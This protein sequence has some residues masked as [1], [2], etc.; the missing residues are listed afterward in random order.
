[1]TTLQG[2][3]D[4]QYAAGRVPGAV[5][6]VSRGGETELAT[7]GER[8]IGGPPMTSDSLFR[9]AS[10]TKP[11]VAAATMVLVERGVLGLDDAVDTW[12][13]EVA[14]P[15][16]LRDAGGPLD[17]VVPADRAITV[18][19]LLTLRGGHGFTADVQ[20]P[21]ARALQER[22]QQGPP[23]PRSVP[24]PDEWMARLGD[25]PLAHQPGEGWT[26]NVGSDVLGVLLARATKTSL[27]ELLTGVVFE[28]LAMRDTGFWM[29]DVE[30]LTSYYQ[31]GRDGL[32]LVDPPDGQ[33]SSP[34]PFESGAG[35]LVSTVHDWATFARMLLDDGGNVLRP[36]SVRLMMTNHVEAE[37]DNPFL[38]GQGWGFGGGVDV[39]RKDP[40]N[41]VGRYGWVGGT[42]TAGY[43]IPSS[44]TVVVWLSQVELSGSEG[45]VALAEVLTYA[46][47]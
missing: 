33:W 24:P 47:R 32:E 44:G 29:P 42:G 10:I 36:E 15:M 14:E 39:R 31:Q 37:P 38:D 35:G 41:V 21:L 30:R 1:M 25:L 46:A 6:L 5:A 11:I 18:R 28:P 20:T 17:E 3:L 34:P 12:L 2:L 45:M 8:T 13:P 4:E 9:I 27:G 43:V 22:L 19:D 26:Y 16:V 40:W 23:R 7:V